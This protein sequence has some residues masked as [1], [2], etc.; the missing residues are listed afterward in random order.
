MAFKYNTLKTVTFCLIGVVVA[1]TWMV[2]GCLAADKGVSIRSI[3]PIL[4]LNSPEAN[5]RAQ[6]YFDVVGTLNLVE[7]DRIIIGDR[8][9]SLSSGVKASGI[10]KWDHVGAKLNPA[11]EVV[12]L[13]KLTDE[14]H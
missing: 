13:V 11:G 6:D 10:Q 5:I 2:S 3:T 7:S 1:G 12:S 4:E 14:P 9:L 8:V